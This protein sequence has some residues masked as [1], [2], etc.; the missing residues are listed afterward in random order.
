MDPEI[1]RAAAAAITIIA[2][3]MVAANL[4]ARIT[5]WGFAIFTVASI[6]WIADGVLEGKTSLG[7]Q[8]VVL[9]LIN[10]LGVWRWLPRAGKEAGAI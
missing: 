1:L 9:L 4:N 8:N 5:V 6:A 2:A 10:V 7:V 3:T